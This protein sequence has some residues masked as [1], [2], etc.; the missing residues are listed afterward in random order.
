ME[1]KLT[2]FIFDKMAVPSFQKYLNLGSYRQKLISGNLANVSTPG[3]RAQDI[4]FQEEFNRATT[5]HGQVDGLVTHPSHLPLGNHPDRAP[6]VE[7]EKVPDG[8]INS[9]DLDRQA[10]TMAENELLYTVAARLIARRFAGLRSAIKS[11]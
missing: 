4:R 5:K 8:E 1:T 11:Q 3:Y 7:R 10:T 6:R 9:V 2:Q